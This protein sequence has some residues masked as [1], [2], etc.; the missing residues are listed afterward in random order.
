VFSQGRRRLI[1]SG[2]GWLR[3]QRHVER[4]TAPSAELRLGQAASRGCGFSC[5]ADVH[6]LPQPFVNQ[7]LAETPLI[8]HLVSGELPLRHQPID[9]ELIYLQILGDLFCG[10]QSVQHTVLDLG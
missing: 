2:K 7:L 1:V 4:I 8:P 10:E 9:S 5:T 6:V 3:V